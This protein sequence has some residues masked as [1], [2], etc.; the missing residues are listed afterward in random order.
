MYRTP[1]NHMK[2]IQ[3]YNYET[4]HSKSKLENTL[5]DNNSIIFQ[6][7]CHVISKN[8]MYSLSLIALILMAFSLVGI[9]HDVKAET[10]S[11]SK[12]DIPEKNNTNSYYVSLNIV[13]K[14][15]NNTSN[16]F[17]P[18]QTISVNGSVIDSTNVPVSKKV[19]II[20]AFKEDNKPIHRSF[21]TTDN[22]GRFSDS[23]VVQ[24]Q[25]AVKITARLAGS[26]SQ[27]NPIITIS[28]SKPLWPLYVVIILIA[29]AFS[30]VLFGSIKEEKLVI[31][32]VVSIVAVG[33]VIVYTLSPLDTAGNTALVGALLAPI[34]AYAVD[35]LKKEYEKKSTLE[36]AVGTYRNTNLTTEVTNSV[37]IY[38]EIS[39]HQSI[40]SS[41]IDDSSMKL[42]K[43]NFDPTTKVGTMANLPGLR[44]NRYYHNVNIYNKLLDAKTNDKQFNDENKR[45]QFEEAFQKVK[46]SYSELNGILYVNIIYNIAEIQQTYLSFPTVKL[47]PRISS[48]LLQMLERSGILKLEQDGRTVKNRKDLDHIYDEENTDK[49]MT[50][51]SKEFKTSYDAL[52]VAIKDAL[53]KMN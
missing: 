23:L 37:K 9:F 10:N 8:S 29:G 25:G 17:S 18:G 35:F 1:I 5:S 31:L 51:I 39:A 3:W 4:K 13:N 30:L 15:W 2:S 34:A 50:Q 43:T 44:V 32:G 53:L 45:K 20:E 27:D 22:L 12:L 28:V 48:T 24:E 38:D 7:M 14:N 49:M 6:A 21:T 11:T 26:T 46:N 33:Y 19:V 40:F 47:P 16:V 42:S 41:K 36:T 52:E